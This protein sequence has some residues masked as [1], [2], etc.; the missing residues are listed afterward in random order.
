MVYKINTSVEIET[1][2]QSTY[3]QQ[4]YKSLYMY[5]LYVCGGDLSLFD[6]L[7]LEGMDTTL[8]EL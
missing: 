5:L 2:N 6:N 4:E 7:D 8:I 1:Y 3:I